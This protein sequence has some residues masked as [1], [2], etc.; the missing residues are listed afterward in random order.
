MLISIQCV[1]NGVLFYK[2]CAVREYFFHLA[3]NAGNTQLTS[4]TDHSVSDTFYTHIC[5][6]PKTLTCFKLNPD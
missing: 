6:S 1:Q 4:K 2:N 3:T 5:S